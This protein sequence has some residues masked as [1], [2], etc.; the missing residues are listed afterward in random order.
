MKHQTSVIFK[1]EQKERLQELFILNAMK[2]DELAHIFSLV[3][4][5]SGVDMVEFQLFDEEFDWH[6]AKLPQNQKANYG[7][8][9]FS[10]KL[11]TNKKLQLEIADINS[12]PDFV[13]EKHFVAKEN[14]S[15]YFGTALKSE[16]GHYLGVLCI[17]QDKP[18]TL[19]TVQKEGFTALVN[20]IWQS[21]ALKKAKKNIMSICEKKEAKVKA[22]HH[23]LHSFTQEL[24][25]PTLHLKTSIDT[26]IKENGHLDSYLE[27]WISNISTNADT[28]NQT[29]SGM[30]DYMLYNTTPIAY[31][32]FNLKDVIAKIK[33]QID[34]NNRLTLISENTE[35]EVY[36]FKKGLEF[37]LTN[38]FS[39][40][41]LD[42]SNGRYCKLSYHK[43]DTYH[44]LIYSD[45]GPN[46]KEHYPDQIF[47]M[48]YT[49]KHE[50]CNQRTFGLATAKCLAE[51]MDGSLSIMEPTAKNSLTFKLFLPVV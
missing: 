15:Y 8:L 9:S 27:T 45:C 14:I 41:I 6:T 7:A 25:A 29:L 10:K 18:F 35:E 12:H 19:T 47:E 28:L 37:L 26:F 36:L 2:Q 32:H 17:Y 3:R 24:I 51:R 50:T 23:E 34:P 13:F 4:A 40:S 39:N 43:T 49:K 46:I 21:V 16:I 5:I 44:E 11:I 22:L 31:S 20:Q 48:F 30:L 33:N 1:T 38:L 42:T